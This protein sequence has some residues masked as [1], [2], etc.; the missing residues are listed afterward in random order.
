MSLIVFRLELGSNQSSA[1][2]FPV[3]PHLLSTADQASTQLCFQTPCFAV[4]P[5]KW[6]RN[7]NVMRVQKMCCFWPNLDTAILSYTCYPAGREDN[8]E[9]FRGLIVDNLGDS[10]RGQPIL[11]EIG[12]KIEQKSCT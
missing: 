12:K 8:L 5:R 4:V 1:Y 6:S 2:I 11:G 10:C 7:P 9:A 3:T